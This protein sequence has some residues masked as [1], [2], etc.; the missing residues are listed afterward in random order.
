MFSGTKSDVAKT[1]IQL[2]LFKI[3][4][5][6]CYAELLLVTLPKNNLRVRDISSS[7]LQLPPLKAHTLTFYLC[8]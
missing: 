8:L 5:A 7:R 3:S 1:R 4:D 6:T 2:D